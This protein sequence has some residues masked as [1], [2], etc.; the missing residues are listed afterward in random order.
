MSSINNKDT[1]KATRLRIPPI[2][3]NNS[4]VILTLFQIREASD[5]ELNTFF[6]P[7]ISTSILR[8]VVF[9]FLYAATAL[10]IELASSLYLQI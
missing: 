10:P 6:C 2:K 4:I 8:F 1:M 9:D 7:S 5:I 3:R